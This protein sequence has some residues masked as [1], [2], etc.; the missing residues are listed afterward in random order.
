MICERHFSS[1]EYTPSPPEM[2]ER[3]L[4]LEKRLRYRYPRSPFFQI[5]ASLIFIGHISDPQPTVTPEG[6]SFMSVKT[7][8]LLGIRDF[9]KKFKLG[10]YL[11]WIN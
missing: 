2:E 10:S 9:K 1:P 6:S 8:S 11:F 3:F 4:E 7:F 5:N